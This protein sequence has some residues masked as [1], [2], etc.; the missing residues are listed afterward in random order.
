MFEETF[1]KGV[2]TVQIQTL[3]IE[4]FLILRTPE[5]K[6]KEMDH[7]HDHGMSGVEEVV[8]KMDMSV[9]KLIR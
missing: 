8:C 4:S 6:I 3:M 9:R 2:R 7:D 5:H 1:H